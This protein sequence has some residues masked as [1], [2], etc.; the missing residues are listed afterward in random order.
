M[1]GSF[2]ELRGRV[3]GQVF[4]ADDPGYDEA[5]AVW[6]AMIDRRP[7]AVVCAAAVEDVAPTIAFAR[8]HGL[9]LAI[10]GGGHNVAGNGTV[11]DG[12][13]L[14]LGGLASV[15]VDPDRRLVH[16]QGGATL[17][18]IDAATEPYGLMVPLGVVSGTGVA[19]LTLGG[20]VGWLTRL[21]GLTADNLARVELVTATG[22]TLAASK[23][24]NAD[25]FWALKGGGGN[26]GVATGFT[27]RAYP[28]GRALYCGTLAYGADGWNRAWRALAEWTPDLPDEMTTVTTTTTPPPM[29][30]MG[31][32]PLLLVGFAWAGADRARG[33]RLVERL[34]QLA[35]PDD[36]Q[37]GETP[38]LEW[39]SAL[40]PLVPKGVRAY[41]RN[42][43]FDRLSDGLI[44][45]L[46]D[47][48]KE[49][50][51][52]GTAF[53]VHHLGGAFSRVAED[54]TPFPN[55]NAQ[56]WINIYGF[57]SETVD[58]LARVG[59]IRSLSEELEQF[60]TGGHYVN[61][62]GVEREGH[63]TLDPRQTFGPQKYERLVEVKRI[64][65]PENVFHINHNISPA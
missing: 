11:E 31:D 19:G 33:E 36:E 51:W 9:D 21:H 24:E 47:R 2:E 65:D 5:R 6:N 55:R 27:F 7:A 38:W 15:T 13:V 48:G 14:D 17:K 8:E 10:R 32:Q 64:Y 57:W 62:Q 16:A 39:Q 28:H 3:S 54:A 53:D 12:I 44:D 52:V 30:D 45:V 40:D 42:A 23:N 58:D 25:L 46:I 26:F 41:W 61:F 43:S 4:T 59:F 18:D 20:G 56:Y 34:R 22:E 60:A 50:T 49:Q 1:S 63:R 35:P 29:M 37:V